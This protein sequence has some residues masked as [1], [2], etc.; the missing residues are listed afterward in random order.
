[1][2]WLSTQKTLNSKV[3]FIGK[4][5]HSGRI[6][7]MEVCPAKPNTGIVFKRVDNF[8]TTYTKAIYKNVRD[9]T[10]CTVLN[11]GSNAVGTV[12]HLLAALFVL[13]IDNAVININGPEVP[14]LDGSAYQFVQAFLNAGL[15]YQKALKKFYIVKKTFE[16]VSGDKVFR[17]EPNN[18]PVFCCEIDYPNSFIGHQKVEL[19]LNDINK[20][21][22]ISKARTFCH[23]KDVEMLKSLGFALGGSLENAVVVGNDG[24][25]NKDGLRMENEFAWHKVIDAIGDVS[26]FGA[27]IVGKIT[28]IKGGHKFHYEAIC[29]LAQAKSKYLLSVEPAKQ[30]IQFKD[31]LKSIPVLNEVPNF[32]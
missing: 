20:F 5:V 26:L 14:I 4:G 9:T 27:P 16:Y 31:N 13:G 28:V 1:M 2:D 29:A 18:K 23:L 32:V 25:I 8:R 17:L 11:Q 10:L 3:Y 21:K 12:E 30:G 22:E 15:L 7:K 6:V 19:D 24:V